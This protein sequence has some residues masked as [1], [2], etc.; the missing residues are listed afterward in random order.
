MKEISRRKFL[1]ISAL[2][3]A[4]TM[5]PM[6]FRWLGSG[7]ANAFSNSPNLSKWF[8]GLGAPLPLRGLGAGRS[9]NTIQVL[10]STPD[11]G[12]AN[13]N[14]Y[15]VTASEFTDQ[16]HPALGPTRLWGYRATNA[17]ATEQSHLGGLIVAVR[18]TASRIRF[19]NT[20]PSQHIIPIDTTLP[21]ANQ[22]QNRIAIHLHGGY[23][24]WISD[25]GPFD[26]WTPAGVGGLSFQNGPT[27]LFDNIATQ[28]MVPGQADY[29]Y[30]ND[31]STRLMWYHDHAHGI[32]RTNAYA[33]LATGYLVVDP[34][35][36]AK[37]GNMAPTL[38]GP[39]FIPLVYQDK[40][41]VGPNTAVTD[42]TWG[43]PGGATGVSRSDVRTLGS[44]WY[45][46]VYDPRAFRMKKGRGILPAP[47][48]SCVPEFFG[49]TMLVN[50][51]V[52]PLVELEA[53]RYRF[54]LL[55][56]CNARFLNINLLEVM[57]GY[58][59]KTDP[60]TLLPVDQV[61]MATGVPFAAT[62]TPPVAGPPII[63]IGTEGGYLY[64]EV[65]LTNNVFFNP[66]L[67]SVGNLMLG[68]A[69][70]A[71]IIIDFT[72]KAG[73]D[74]IFYNDAFGPFPAGPPANDY[75][76]GNPA[77]PAA[78]FGSSPD[79]R[80]IT[81]FRIKAALVA[82]PQPAGAIIPANIMDPP[83]HINPALLAVG[84][85]APPAGARII[86]LTLNEDFDPYGR[87]RQLVG[88]T[89]P[90][91]IGK[92]FGLEYLQPVQPEEI[93]PQGELNVW[94]VFNTTAD[95][96]P[97]HFHLQDCQV[98]SRQPFKI[99]AGLF[100]PTGA[101]RGPEKTELGWKETVKMNPG[102]VTTVIFKWDQPASPFTV[103]SSA[104]AT[105]TAAD[106][107]KLPAGTIYN[108]YVWHC[109]ILEHEEHDMMRP[110]IITGP[111]PQRPNITPTSG[112]LLASVVGTQ[113]F[114]VTVAPLTTFTVTTDSLVV[115]AGNIV[116]QVDATATTPLVPGS[117]DVVFSA[118]VPTGNVT[119]TVTDS[120]GLK[121]T[122]VVALI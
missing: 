38:G 5:M 92:G 32:T 86:N 106:G 120:T 66:A 110:L 70:R 33:G 121:S 24:P 49:D 105:N 17:L 83:P 36:E 78:T 26:W 58:E 1:Q 109:H 93:I 34:A 82:D 76:A 12:F 46:H 37:I 20:L 41:F 81:R 114:Q 97:M 57:A 2:A 6:P 65:T 42:P 19:T 119:F 62:P 31:Q 56:A 73:K 21:G 88:T 28:P 77:T 117:F 80:Q 29:F 15:E 9:T 87:L 47:N 40:V 44:L 4:A 11:K 14:F 50:G 64:Q 75:F 39:S 101:A 48:P 122:V 45:D 91:L 84:P 54:M 115:T 104:R 111:A 85:V 100:T 52:T 116:Q 90:A 89:R 59:I 61:A 23:I 113:T 63:Q 68:C 25:G 102:E 27:S 43:V 55:N 13:T 71:D 112:S 118:P 95:T 60:L 103:P 35:Q 16:L 79:T 72:G 51:T 107:M 98:L 18:G 69:E 10:G 108:E 3:G 8:D 74:F 53:K 30:P 67:P 99:V 96:H 7:T 94:R 22:A